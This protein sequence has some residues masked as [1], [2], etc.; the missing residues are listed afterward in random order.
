M[1]SDDEGVAFTSWWEARRARVR[2]HIYIASLLSCRKSSERSRY[3][4]RRP[5][6]PSGNCT[7]E[8][9]MLASAASR[10]IRRFQ[11]PEFDCAFVE[12]GALVLG[13][14]NGRRTAGR[15]HETSSPTN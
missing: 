1:T 2:E 3:T 13:L 10:R 6:I 15:N 12:R 4:Q 14:V 11:P 5:A 8:R 9:P 7:F